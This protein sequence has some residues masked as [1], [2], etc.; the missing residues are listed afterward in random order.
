M[1]KFDIFGSDCINII[2]YEFGIVHVPTSSL[3][4]YSIGDYG[5]T[6]IPKCFGLTDSTSLEASGVARV[7][8]LPNFALRVQGILVGI[9]D[10]GIDYRDNIFINADNTTKIVSIWDQTIDSENAYPTDI[11]YGTEY[12]RDQINRALQNENPLTIV[13]SND[14]IGHGTFLAGI[15]AG[16]EDKK[17][18]F[19]GVVPDAELVVVKLKKAK[20]YLK[21]FFN[22]PEEALCYQE[23]DIMFG[24]KYITDV[25]KKLNRPIALCIG[26]GT[27]QGSHDGNGNLEQYLETLGDTIGNAVVI[28][29]GNEGNR[30]HHYFGEVDQT[31]TY[32]TVELK[33]GENEK[34]FS[35][36][37]WGH[38][39][40]IFSIDIL[41]PR[42]EYIPRI[43]ARIRESRD[44]TFI[45]ENTIIL[46]D[47]IL[48]TRKA[49][50][51]LILIRFKNPT[52][53][54]WR[55]RIY[56]KGDISPRFHIW[57]P[58]E[59]FITEDT[60]FINPNPDTT[61]TGPG[62]GIIPISV[63]AYN[64]L[65][66]NIYLYSSRGFTRGDK[67]QPTITAPGVDIFGP[68]GGKKYTTS[69]GTSIAAAHTTGVAAMLLEWGILRGNA[70]TI[71]TFEIKKY[72]IRGA[73]R[74]I[75]NT[76]PNKEWGYGILDIYRVFENLILESEL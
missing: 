55:F 39:P 73:R 52:P 44:I 64:H 14:D 35:M 59:K 48:I 37:L 33:V 27:N 41:S 9:V 22:I 50:D 21:E 70:N 57:L 63:V 23:N 58:M 25:A 43:P 19:R 8:N 6:V 24:V 68:I 29:G 76:Y 4:R 26:I 46:V 38:E 54:I 28:A 13:P 66:G 72:L 47:Y 30:G 71:D 51:E 18:D 42:G 15:A 31:I 12:S 16:G 45:F 75:E 17:N 3:T 53:G 62:N 5:Y 65:K 36:E 32:D 7:Q 74:N 61:I 11:Y 67:V 34:G 10:T 1:R 40:N 49:G 69:S 56:A 60:L 2:N 20:N